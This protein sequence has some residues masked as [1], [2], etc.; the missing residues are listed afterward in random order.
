M[1]QETG[2]VL[3][4]AVAAADTGLLQ[5]GRAS[6]VCSGAS[7]GHG[8]AAASALPRNM[9]RHDKW[10]SHSS[11]PLPPS[12][13]HPQEAG[14]V[15][16]A[17][18]AAAD[19]DLL[20]RLLS[21][22]VHPSASDYD[23]RSPLHIAAIKGHLHVACLLVDHHADVAARDSVAA[24]VGVLQKGGREVQGGDAET[25]EVASGNCAEFTGVQ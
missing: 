9:L 18:V 17:A 22:G 10:S 12:L 6:A 25:M 14:P 20:Q 2:P 13:T 3:C 1:A 7:S 8:P 15:L 19:T 16:C 24:T 23:Q 11:E 21:H 4:A 5:R